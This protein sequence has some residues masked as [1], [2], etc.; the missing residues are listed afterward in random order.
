[1]QRG[2]ERVAERGAVRVQSGCSQGAARVQPR[3]RGVRRGEE[4]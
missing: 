2:A 4:G 3:C 1:M